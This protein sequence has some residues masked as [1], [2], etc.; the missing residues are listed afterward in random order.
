MM[1]R[2]WQRCAK[3]YSADERRIYATGFSNGGFFTYLLWAQRP[4]IFAAFAPGAAAILPSFYL[5]EPRPALHFGGE[6][7]MLV[8]FKD[9]QKQSRKSRKFNGCTE[10]GEPCGDNCVLYPSAIGA[11]L[12]T[13]IFPR[14]HIYPPQVTKLSSLN[15]FKRNPE[16][17]YKG[18]AVIRLD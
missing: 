14:G 7:D 11:P 13:F 17:E 5:T 1:T 6:S 9:Q 16:A 8:L 2:Y 15:S 3:K 10:R 18:R 4:K 12:E